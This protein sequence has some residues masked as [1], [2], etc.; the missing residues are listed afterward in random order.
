[1]RAI[2]LLLLA[3]LAGCWLARSAI[4]AIANRVVERIEQ[5]INEKARQRQLQRRQ[6]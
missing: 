4:D 5:R 2:G 1:M 6:P 3:L